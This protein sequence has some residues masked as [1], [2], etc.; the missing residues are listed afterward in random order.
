MIGKITPLNI[1][2]RSKD[3]F[4]NNEKKDINIFLK[5]TNNIKMSI[6]SS[7]NTISAKQ[8]YSCKNF[9]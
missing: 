2:I 8:R 9:A 3:I 4:T 1:A 6:S 5:K 7:S